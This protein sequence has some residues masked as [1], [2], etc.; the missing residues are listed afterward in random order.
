[1]AGVQGVRCPAPRPRHLVRA[2]KVRPQGRPKTWHLALGET[3]PACPPAQPPGPGLCLQRPCC[4]QGN[5]ASAGV[6]STSSA[7]PHAVSCHEVA[8][9]PDQSLSV[10]SASREPTITAHSWPHLT[11]KRRL[12]FKSS[13]INKRAQGRRQFHF[14]VWSL[15]RGTVESSADGSSPALRC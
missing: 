3:I 12:G 6:G 8:Q 13:L 4:G 9:S 1:M 14:T 10:P 5:P 7:V 11:H 15:G 2:W